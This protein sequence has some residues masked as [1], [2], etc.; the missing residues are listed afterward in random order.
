MHVLLIKSTSLLVRKKKLLLKYNKIVILKKVSFGVI[1]KNLT[2]CLKL[3]FY[4]QDN[5]NPEPYFRPIFK[6]VLKFRMKILYN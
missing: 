6:N 4:H 2:T 5:I 1:Q 3:I